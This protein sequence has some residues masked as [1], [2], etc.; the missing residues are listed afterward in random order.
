M[1]KVQYATLA[2]SVRCARVRSDDLQCFDH[3]SLL[4]KP[5][6]AKTLSMLYNHCASHFHK[7]VEE[8]HADLMHGLKCLLC[9]FMFKSKYMLTN[10]IAC[11]H[12]KINDILTENGYKV[13]PCPIN[14]VKQDEIQRNMISIKKERMEGD[15]TWMEGQ[16]KDE[17]LP[18]TP[19]GTQEQNYHAQ[20]LNEILAKYSNKSSKK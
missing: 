11:K 17:S 14:G 3:F 9:G 4:T 18:Q 16:A 8:K 6:Q 10:H 13:L 15:V 7:R 12:G 19:P 1:L 5:F 2:L 20:E